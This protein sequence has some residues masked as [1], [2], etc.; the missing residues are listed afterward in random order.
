LLCVL[1][2]VFVYVLFVVLCRVGLLCAGVIGV[3]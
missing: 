2:V 1:C 3:Y